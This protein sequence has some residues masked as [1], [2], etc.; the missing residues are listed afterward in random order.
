MSRPFKGF[1][2]LR[3][4]SGFGRYSFGKGTNYELKNKEQNFEK[5]NF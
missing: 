5:K 4:G 3:L 1:T 2:S